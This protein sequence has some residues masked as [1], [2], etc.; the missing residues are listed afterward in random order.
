[1]FPWDRSGGIEQGL[2]VSD[3]ILRMITHEVVHYELNLHTRE[4]DQI[5]VMHSVKDSQDVISTHLCR[6]IPRVNCSTRS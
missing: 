5:W 2:Q 6:L 3:P 1:M 4:C